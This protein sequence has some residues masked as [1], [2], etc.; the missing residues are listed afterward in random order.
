MFFLVITL[1]VPAQG[2]PDSQK[3]P[4]MKEQHRNQKKYARK[5]HRRHI[6][7]GTAYLEEYNMVNGAYPI[8]ILIEKNNSA[9]IA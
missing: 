7:R 6:K 4:K 1:L 5:A 3:Q 2:F 8:C 9:N